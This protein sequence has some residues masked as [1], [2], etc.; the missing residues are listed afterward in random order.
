MNGPRTDGMEAASPVTHRT[1]WIALALS[2]FAAL[3]LVHRF[4]NTPAMMW[5]DSCCQAYYGWRV[6][7]GD[8]LYRDLWEPH[9]PGAI[10]FS[11]LF[12]LALPNSDLTLKL[13]LLLVASAIG[14]LV[15]DAA[16]RFARV[17][18]PEAVLAGVLMTLVQYTAILAL[19]PEATLALGSLGA[20]H[21]A[22]RAVRAAHPSRCLVL[23]GLCAGTALVSKP[24]AAAAWVVALLVASYGAGS[25][26]PARGATFAAASA[27]L[28]ALWL[29]WLIATGS[30]P[31]AWDNIVIYGRAYFPPVTEQTIRKAAEV[32]LG[33]PRGLLLL[34]LFGLAVASARVWWPALADNMLGRPCRLLFT[35]LFVIWPVLEA[36]VT[37]PQST[38]FPYIFDNLHTCLAYLVLLSGMAL[39]GEAG[40]VPMPAAARIASIGGAVLTVRMTGAASEAGVAVVLG[41]VAALLAAVRSLSARDLTLLGLSASLLA[42]PRAFEG[43]VL[44]RPAEWTSFRWWTSPEERFARDKLARLKERAGGKLLAFTACP[45]HAYYAEWELALRY[46]VVFPIY[47]PAGYGSSARW[48]EV[49]QVIDRPDTHIMLDWPQWYDVTRD[50]AVMRAHMVPEYFEAL[51]HLR[52]KFRLVKTVDVGYGPLRIWADQASETAAVEILR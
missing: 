27:V 16:R 52:Q 45:S 15:A 51:E 29:L 5:P 40:E 3:A 12:H 21:F 13:L 48:R 49:I 36:L 19:R 14:G 10:V 33:S 35:F 39:A 4:V 38:V 47:T 34:T 17:G 9:P 41:A 6:A 20:V 42:F 22:L 30:L 46:H 11:S 2:G 7:Q 37:I 44:P 18:W 26:R 31:A 1:A 8:I 25:L 32:G 50:D 28:P 23:A 43:R 24:G